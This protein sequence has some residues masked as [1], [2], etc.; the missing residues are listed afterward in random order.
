[1]K[2]ILLSLEENNVRIAQNQRQY[3][4]SQMKWLHFQSIMF[5]ALATYF[6]L[7]PLLGGS[8][9]Y[10]VTGVIYL[11]VVVF[12]YRMLFPRQVS[13]VWSANRKIAEA[14]LRMRKLIEE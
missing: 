7:S 9:W 11:S 5:S 3:A 14:N 10:L 6:C 2:E 1:M 4:K 13:A 8:W 12:T